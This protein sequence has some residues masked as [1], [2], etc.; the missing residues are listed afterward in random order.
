M[1]IG[2]PFGLLPVALALLSLGAAPSVRAQAAADSAFSFSGFG[3][4]GL[5]Q[6]NSDIGRYALYGQPRGADD[7]VSGEVDSK[8]GLQVSAKANAMFSGTVQLLTKQDGKGKFTPAIEWAFVKAQL[9]PSLSLRL[10]RMGGPFFA[11]S[12]FRDVGY[13]NTWLRPPQDVY[14][15]VPVSHF[16]GAD[17]SY[18]MPLGSATMTAQVFAG[19]ASSYV[20]GVKVQLDRLRGV[21][22]SVE[23]DNGLTLRF[24]HV[25]G[26]ITVGS[27]TIAGLVG[28]LRNPQLAPLSPNFAILAEQLDPNRKTATFTGFGAA[29]DQGAWVANFEYTQR[30]TD[31]YV[32]DTN[33]WYGTVGYRIGK[34][35]PYVTVSKLAL[36]DANAVNNI[37]APTPQLAGLKA[38]VNL[39]LA[40]QAVDQKT[41]ALG[42][43]WDAIRNVA[44][45]AQFERI[46]PKTQGLFLVPANGT[47]VGRVNVYSLAVDTVF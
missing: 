5:V 32:A 9:L 4:L 8:L 38:G 3:T 14:G 23:L 40:G 11:V 1:R 2:K 45:K 43:R 17:A 21:N 18:Q 26:K 10:G 19:K 44:V 7:S 47:A 42:L 31:S 20:T 16:D 24:G 36:A 41:A 12:D 34:F 33:G 30:R 25:A 29:Y 6:T 28:A 27:S 46:S 13:A 35:T 15:Q 39:V 22:A 37:P